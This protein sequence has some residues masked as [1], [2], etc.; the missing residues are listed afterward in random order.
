[1]KNFSNS[2]N[3]KKRTN[4][5]ISKKIQ[6]AIYSFI[7]GFEGRKGYNFKVKKVGNCRKYLYQ[8]LNLNER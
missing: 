5:Y 6:Y 1:M 4:H 2:W 3:K 7:F 8:E